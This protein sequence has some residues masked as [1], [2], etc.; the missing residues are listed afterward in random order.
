M[1]RA[2][3]ADRREPGRRIHA[4]RHQP[5]RLQDASDQARI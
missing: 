1:G 5:Y 3:R 2:G 4:P